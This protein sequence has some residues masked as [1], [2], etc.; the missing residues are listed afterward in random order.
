MRLPERPCLTGGPSTTSAAD[1]DADGYTDWAEYA[2]GTVPTNAAS[3]LSFNL[4]R[5]GANHLSAMVSPF[6]AGRS[7][8]LE[9]KL[10]PAGWIGLTNLPLPN[11]NGSAVF[12]LTNVFDSIRLIRLKADWTP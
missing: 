7:Y 4:E 1:H 10:E 9:Q 12:T 3:R 5:I 6:Q 11:S 8:Q 2:L